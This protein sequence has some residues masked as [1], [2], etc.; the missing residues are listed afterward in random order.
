MAQMPLNVISW[1]NR[2][3]FL[4]HNPW[5]TVKF[6]LENVSRLGGVEIGVQVLSRKWQAVGRR[7]GILSGGIGLLQPKRFDGWS[8]LKNPGVKTKFSPAHLHPM[9][10]KIQ[11]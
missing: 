4:S 1:R 7:I 9:Y 6:L 10:T 5:K 2:L 11:Y 8:Q 3:T